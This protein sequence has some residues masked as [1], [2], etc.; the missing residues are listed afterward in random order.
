MEQNQASRSALFS[1]YLRG[2]HSEHVNPKIFNDSLAKKFLTPE[3]RMSFDKYVLS[4]LMAYDPKLAAL[5]PDEA[6][7]LAFTMQIIP[8]PP[9]ILSRA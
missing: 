6:T 1:A 4:G 8:G 9:Q 7:A 5:F 2:Y 3:E